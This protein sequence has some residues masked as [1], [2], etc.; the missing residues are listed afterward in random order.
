MSTKDAVS[1]PQR[2]GVAALLYL[3]VAATAMPALAAPGDEARARFEAAWQSARSGDRTRF[4]ALGPGLQDYI[5]YPYWQYEDYRYRRATAD[6]DE[7]ADFLD[8]HTDWAFS[9]ALRRAWL[10]SLGERQRWEALRRYGASADT[11][12]NRCYH[13]RA[14][15]AADDTTGLL[16]QARDLW[17]VGHSQPDACDPLFTWMQGQGA[18]DAE[19]AWTRIDRAMAEGNPGLTRYLARFISNADR[20]WL[21]RWLQLERGGYRDLGKA[22]TWPD[23]PITR[24]MTETS[25]RRLLKR[26]PAAAMTVFDQ[27]DGRFSWSEQARGDLMREIALMAAVDLDPGAADFIARVPPAHLDDQLTQWWARL[28]LAE[29]D[30]PTLVMVTARM[31]GE[32]ADDDRWRY[33]RARALAETGHDE[34]AEPMF[35]A[36]ATETNYYAFLAADRLDWPYTICELPPAVSDDAV[37]AVRSRADIARALELHRVDLENWARAEW[38]R[39]MRRMDVDSLRAAAAVARE[40]GWY[41]R[42]I[43]AL[44]DSGDLRW[45]EW[46]FPVMFEAPVT[47]AA[48]RE[49]LDAAWVYGI[50]RSESAMMETARSSANALGLMQVTPGTARTIASKH[51]LAYRS[52]SQLL[53]GPTNIQFGTTFLRDLLDEYAQNPVLV[54]GAYNAGPNAVNR[55]LRSRPRGEAAAWVET[56]P[57]YETRDYIPRVLAFTTIYEWRLGLPVRR[58]SARMPDIESGSIAND[59]TTEVVCSAR[60][61]ELAANLP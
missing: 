27:L 32:T 19:L 60:P 26:D 33:W 29:S 28:A 45:Y 44:G 40:E 5:L 18:I 1:I 30:W 39:A 12:E 16:A 57:Y 20:A 3:G 46:R 15:L 25:L 22:A 56:L 51:G 7:V 34:L 42:A 14:R 52:S 53:D 49:K 2:L 47:Q 8:A 11:D 58:V 23:T 54:S 4:E 55:W 59:E 13:A 6:P 21:E 10:R 48:A 41:D 38:G 37:A 50:M 35:A 9:T 24:R 43:F 31:A 17:T 61:A 36:L